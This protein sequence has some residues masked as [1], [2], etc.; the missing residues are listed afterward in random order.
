ME[1]PC[2]PLPGRVSPR[3]W[4][5]EHVQWHPLPSRKTSIDSGVAAKLSEDADQNEGIIYDALI[6]RYLYAE[7]AEFAV[8]S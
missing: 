4:L 5:P 8:C 6:H 1:R 3:H 7:C 2:L